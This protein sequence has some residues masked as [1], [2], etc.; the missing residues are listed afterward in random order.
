[1]RKKDFHNKGMMNFDLLLLNSV[2]TIFF[3]GLY[4]KSVESCS[5]KRKRI[6]KTTTP[7]EK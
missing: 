3:S 4:I 1:M 7:F 2:F 5:G 6:K